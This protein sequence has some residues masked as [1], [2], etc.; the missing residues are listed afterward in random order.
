MV[1]TGLMRGVGG[2]LRRFLGNSLSNR[3]LAFGAG[4]GVTVLLQSSSATCLLVTSFAE[5]G[6]MATA[7]ALAVMLG[8]DVGTS[9]VAQLLS[10]NLRW[11][12]PLLILAGVIAFMTGSSG[13]SR[14][15]GR[16]VIGLGLMLLALRL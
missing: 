13:R 2:D 15:L 14:D 10:L 8:A 5:R 16:A 4:L 9:L 11:L 6:L 12:S 3:V 7:P 1:R